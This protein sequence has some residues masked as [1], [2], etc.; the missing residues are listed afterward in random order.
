VFDTGSLG[1]GDNNEEKES[2]ES[3]NQSG[4]D[5]DTVWDFDAFSIRMPM[6]KNQHH[7]LNRDSRR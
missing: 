7:F 3:G 2:R 6:G 1:N 4:L 5:P